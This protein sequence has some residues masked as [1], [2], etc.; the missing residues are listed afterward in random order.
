MCR[1]GGAGGE[2]LKK[3]LAWAAYPDIQIQSVWREV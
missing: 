2:S 3:P 1:E